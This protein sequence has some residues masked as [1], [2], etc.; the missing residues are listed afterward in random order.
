MYSYNESK[1]LFNYYND[2]LVGK[3]LDKEM[4]ESVQIEY[5]KIEATTKQSY[6]VNCYSQMNSSLLAYKPVHHV[7]GKLELP[8][9]EEVL[10]SAGKRS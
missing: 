6:K 3:P 1:F 7:V 2:L 5:L 9:P 10:K 4:D 8:S